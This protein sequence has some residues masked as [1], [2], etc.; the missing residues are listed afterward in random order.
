MLSNIAEK[1]NSLS[2]SETM[3]KQ[4]HDFCELMAVDR[5]FKGAVDGDDEAGTP[6]SG[7]GDDMDESIAPTPGGAKAVKRKASVSVGGTP[8]K[9]KPARSSIGSKVNKR[10]R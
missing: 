4:C 1:A 2:S 10:I 9:K 6:D 5:E 8:H 7:S 3:L